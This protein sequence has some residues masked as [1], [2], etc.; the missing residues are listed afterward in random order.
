[1]ICFSVHDSWNDHLCLE[2]VAHDDSYNK[3][4]PSD[5]FLYKF[6]KKVEKTPFIFV[7]EHSMRK[8]KCWSLMISVD[9]LH[10]LLTYLEK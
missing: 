1:M 6:S 5:L 9:V 3:Q 8:R 2:N 7:D 10:N 4:E